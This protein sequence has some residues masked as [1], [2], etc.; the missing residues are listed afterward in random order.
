MSG[1]IIPTNL[2]KYIEFGT[3][4]D[5]ELYNQLLNLVLTLWFN[6]DGFQLPQLT[7]TQVTALVA[8]ADTTNLARIWY[9]STTNAL[10]FMG[11]SN[12]VQTI[13]SA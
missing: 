9:N 4:A 3:D 1:S 11:A 13:T 12:V 8:L 6:S 5:K 7:S 2:P 10:Q